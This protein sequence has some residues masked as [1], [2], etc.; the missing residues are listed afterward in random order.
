MDPTTKAYMTR[1]LTE[2]KTKP[3]VMRCLKRYV[4]REIFA[5]IQPSPSPDPAQLAA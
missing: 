2:G 5:A 4:V 3:E 1:R